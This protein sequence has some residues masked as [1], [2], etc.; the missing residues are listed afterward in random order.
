MIERGKHFPA[1]RH[2]NLIAE[3]GCD[4]CACGSKY[5]ENDECIDCGSGIEA[6]RAAENEADA[7]RD[8]FSLYLI[9]TR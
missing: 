5:W 7:M 2:G 1:D 6:V 8:G 3:E 4:R 9:T